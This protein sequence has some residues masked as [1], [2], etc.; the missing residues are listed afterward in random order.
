M[1]VNSL[2]FLVWVL[3]QSSSCICG[4]VII[5]ACCFSV[6]M[7]TIVYLIHSKTTTYILY[8]QCITLSLGLCET[9]VLQYWWKRR[10]SWTFVVS[11]LCMVC[12]VGVVQV[13]S[14]HLW[15]SNMR[16]YKWP[17]L[18]MV[19]VN[20]LSSNNILASCSEAQPRN[21]SG[22]S[23]FVVTRVVCILQCLWYVIWVMAFICNIHWPF[24]GQV[25]CDPFTSHLLPGSKASLTFTLRLW[26]MPP[27]EAMTCVPRGHQA[28]HLC[29]AP[30]W[31]TIS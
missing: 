20:L 18:W 15:T 13:V 9:V 26:G 10:S 24:H 21:P 16:C 2:N 11:L 22:D 29:L 31:W 8:Y 25:H 23:A 7:Y 4:L 17:I 5:V 1:Y 19:N 28:G 12:Q 3:G 14:S 27:S 6:L 30:D